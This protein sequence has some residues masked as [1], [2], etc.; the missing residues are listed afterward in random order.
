ME[1]NRGQ[2]RKEGREGERQAERKKGED[3]KKKLGRWG[4]GRKKP[5]WVYQGPVAGEGKGHGGTF[6]TAKDRPKHGDPEM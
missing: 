3:R 1:G 2:G 6:W 5:A 4:G